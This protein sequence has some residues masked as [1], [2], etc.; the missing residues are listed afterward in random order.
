LVSG[1]SLQS[2]QIDLSEL[3]KIPGYTQPEIQ[4]LKVSREIG[5]D[6]DRPHEWKKSLGNVEMAGYQTSPWF[7]KP[8]QIREGNLTKYVKQP[9]QI[10]EDVSYSYYSLGYKG[11]S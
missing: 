9:Y 6:L 5:L 1:Q 8:Y 11:Y 7:L 2:R 10:R 3:A 4:S